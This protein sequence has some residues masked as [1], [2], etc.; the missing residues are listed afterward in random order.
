MEELVKWCRVVKNKH[1]QYIN[2]INELMWLCKNGIEEGN[3]ST[4]EIAN[5]MMTISQLTGYYDN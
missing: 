3:S 4:E 1:P 5:C 2:E